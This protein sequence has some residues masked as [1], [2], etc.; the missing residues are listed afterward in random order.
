M[1]SKKKKPEQKANDFGKIKQG[2]NRKEG[3][4]SKT[5]SNTE[6]FVKEREQYL[7]KE[8]KILTEHM[9]TYLKRVDHFLWENEFLDKE[10][11]KILEDSKA[12]MTYISKHTQKCQNA[13]ITLNDQNHFDLAQVRKQ[14]E[15]LISQYTAKAKEVRNQ[16]MEMETKYSLMNKEVEDL[17]PFK[18]LQLEQLSRIK[19]LEKELLVTKIQHSEQMHKDILWLLLGHVGTSCCVCTHWRLGLLKVC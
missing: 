6:P 19:E 15:E 14:K 11:Q 10:A 8:Y 5:K 4:I 13:I 9:N 18:D 1:A 16:L 7:Q 12:Y 2:T 17:Q 3:D